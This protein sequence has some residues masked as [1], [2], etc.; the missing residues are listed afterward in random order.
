MGWRMMVLETGT[1]ID[2]DSELLSKIEGE[3]LSDV[4]ISEFA[5]SADDVAN[6]YNL[7]KST[8]YTY[9]YESGVQNPQL[10]KTHDNIKR[11][12]VL[13]QAYLDQANA[14]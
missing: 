10:I 2:G 11:Y 1:I 14:N 12:A 6:A 3:D 8:R 4:D 5:L 7:A 13:K 9:V